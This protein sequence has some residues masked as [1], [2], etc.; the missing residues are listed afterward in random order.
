VFDILG[1]DAATVVSGEM[2][3][4]SHAVSFDARHLTSGV[5]IYQLRSGSTVETKRMVLLK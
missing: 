1:R 4:G 5:Y 2:N 3:E